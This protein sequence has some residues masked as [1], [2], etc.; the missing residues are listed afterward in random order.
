MLVIELPFELCYSRYAN[1]SLQAR[2]YALQNLLDRFYRLF[3][4]QRFSALLAN[5]SRYVVDDQM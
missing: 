5:P 4:E 1:R 2:F 3:V